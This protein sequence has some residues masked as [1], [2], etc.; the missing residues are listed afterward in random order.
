MEHAH[1]V[2]HMAGQAVAHAVAPY[3]FGII[4]NDRVGSEG[5][6]IGTGFGVRWKE[7]FLILTAAH[8]LQQTPDEM[9]YYLLPPLKGL[10][11]VDSAN[12]VWQERVQLE[13]PRILLSDDTPNDDL[14]A[15]ILPAQ[16]PAIGEAHFYKLD[17]SHVSPNLGCEVLFLGY[18]GVRA[19]KI[20]D[21]YVAMLYYDC[22]ETCAG[23]PDEDY[24]PGV[25]L[26]VGH[27]SAE[28]VD[29]HG[30]SGSGI[31]C[32]RSTGPV[33]S[34]NVRLA[35]L[36]THYFADRKALRGYRVE[37]VLGFLR[38]KDVWLAKS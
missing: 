14:A 19:K 35:G 37:A 12:V 28:D 17:E 27:P 18:P 7:N 3:T 21:N 2:E 4:Q 5:R 20:G 31:W 25:H 34:P 16:P 10:Q 9:L 22:G 29:P 13:N 32:S 26:L 38:S 24:D 33:W 23:V 30:L 6:E 36:V 11:M 1:T 15:I 8:T